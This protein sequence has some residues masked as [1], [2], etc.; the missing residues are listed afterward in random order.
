MVGPQEVALEHSGTIR[1][2]SIKDWG[3]GSVYLRGRRWW[4]S[5]PTPSGQRKEST[6]QGDEAKARKVLRD[7]LRSISTTGVSAPRAEKVVI[8]ELLDD[9]LH[10]YKV[11]DKSFDW[12]QMVVEKHLRPAF[13]MTRAAGLGSDHIKRYVMARLAAGRKN[14]TVN[15][16]LALLRRSLKLGSRHEPPKVLRV[17]HIAKLETNNVRKG[18]LEPEQY[19]KL[20]AAAS[21]DLAP[22]IE[23]AYL[24]GCRRGEI[25]GLR[26]S[27]F[28]PSAGI[29]RLNP[30]ET[31]NA[32][33]RT[34]PL[35]PGL[36]ALLLRVKAERDE[37]W[38]WAEYIFTRAGQRILDFRGA[39]EAACTAAGLEGQLF[40]DLRRCGVRNL[41]RAGVPEKVAMTISG[42]KTRAVFDR[43]SIVSERDLHEA[44]AKLSVFLGEEGKPA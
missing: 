16:E 37:T 23:F 29:V 22:I 43:Y 34:I 30:G 4:I 36:K 24:T 25:L 38:P 21:A 17:I 14:A 11:N 39:W 40:H 12:V 32:E 3:E 28:D 18:F 6:K 44:A 7:R 13:G 8:G 33:A 26:W 10:D 42:H 31:K 15:N 35:T 1:R 2:M 27:Q 19:K 20:I 5:Y 41:V 9:L